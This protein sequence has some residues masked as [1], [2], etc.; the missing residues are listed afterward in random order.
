MLRVLSH[1]QVCYI[2]NGN[3]A[4]IQPLAK[5]FDK[6]RNGVKRDGL[7]GHKWLPLKTV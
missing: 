7:L 3:R 1:D 5:P 6:G 2:A 4:C